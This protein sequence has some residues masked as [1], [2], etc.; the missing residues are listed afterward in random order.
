MVS[1]KSR[2]ITILS[3][4][5][6]LQLVGRLELVVCRDRFPDRTTD[7]LRPFDDLE[8]VADLD[9]APGNVAVASNGR[10][11]I[12]LHSDG[13]PPF[14]V[15]EIVNGH[16][17]P[18]PNLAQA[19]Q[20]FTSVLSLRIGP[21]DKTL[22][23]LDHKLYAILG[24]PRFLVI[25]LETGN[26]LDEYIFPIHVA[27]PF[28][29]LNDFAFTSDGKGI[30]MVDYSLWTQKPALVTLDL[31]TRK[32][33]RKLQGHVSVQDAGFDMYIQDADTPFASLRLN[34]FV[35]VCNKIVGGK[36]LEG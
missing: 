10:T 18:Y 25:D 7:P 12:T 28:S 1:M 11:F 2:I 20:L 4:T 8:A 16:A 21:D 13:L 5:I 33:T 29:F 19:K 9:W 34:T 15:A 14:N 22:W 30:V 3:T 36:Q 24:R 31:E 17:E 35:G 27:P 6:V 23:T 32:F 26:V